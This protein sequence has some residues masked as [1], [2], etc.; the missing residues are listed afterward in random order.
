MKT[1][2]KLQTKKEVVKKKDK[3]DVKF[4][5]NFTAIVQTPLIIPKEPIFYYEQ[6]V[7]SDTG[8][9]DEEVE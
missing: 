2:T 3:T 7:E 9:K 6:P 5:S 1:K 8:K 4:C